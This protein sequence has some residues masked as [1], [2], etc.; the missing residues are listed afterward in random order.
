MAQYEPTKINFHRSIEKD[1]KIIAKCFVDQNKYVL[2]HDKLKKREG[3][4]EEKEVWWKDRMMVL[5]NSNFCV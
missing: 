2:T 5:R 4:T 3:L 1:D